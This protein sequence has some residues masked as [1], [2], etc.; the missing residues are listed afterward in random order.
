ML[1]GDASVDVLRSRWFAEII[2][3]TADCLNR[4]VMHLKGCWY[5]MGTA[6]HFSINAAAVGGMGTIRHSCSSLGFEMEGMG[7][8][9]LANC[10]FNVDRMSDAT[11]SQPMTEDEVMAWCSILAG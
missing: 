8:I 6:R 4:T 7:T 3:L 2:L 11:K 5:G 1:A 10:N 9:R